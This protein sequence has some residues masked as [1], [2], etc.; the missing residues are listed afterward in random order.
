MSSKLYKLIP[1]VHQEFVLVVFLMVP[2]SVLQ[3]PWDFKSQLLVDN[4]FLLLMIM[5]LFL[6]FTTNQAS[7]QYK[8]FIALVTGLSLFV[9]GLYALIVYYVDVVSQLP[10]EIMPFVYL[11]FPVWVMLEGILM[12]FLLGFDSSS[13]TSILEQKIVV[14]K[15]RLGDFFMVAIAAALLVYI[16]EWVLLLPWYMTVCLVFSLNLIIINQFRE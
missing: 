3:M 14:T 5:W 12:L 10:N 15:P 7:R 6:V 8:G 11:F 1:H 2:Y 13:K 16:G 9:A 4:V